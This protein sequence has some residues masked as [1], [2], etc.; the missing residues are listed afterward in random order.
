MTGYLAADELPLQRIYRWERERPEAVFLTQPYGGKVRD[1]TWGQAVSEVRRMAHWLEAQGWEPGSRVA[2]LSRNCAWW[3]LA[4][5]AIWMAGHVT[6]PIYPSLKAA[7][8]AQDSGAQRRQGL[9]SGRYRRTRKPPETAHSA[10]SDLRGSPFPLPATVANWPT[11]DEL[12]EANPPVPG[13]PDAVRRRSVHH[14][15]HLRHHRQAQGGD[16]QLRPPAR[17]DAKILAGLMRASPARSAYCRICHWPTSWSAA[18]EG[19][20][21][22][23]GYHLFF[24]EGIDTFLADLARARPTCSFRCRGCCSN[25]SRECSPRS[26]RDSWSGCCASP[27]F[28]VLVKQRILRQ[29]GLEHRAQRRLRG[30]A[31]AAG[32]APLV[33]Q[34]GAGPAGRLRH[35]RNHD[36]PP[37]APRR[38]VRP[39]YVGAALE[40]VETRLGPQD[41][42][43]VRSP[44]N[45]AGLFPGAG[46]DGARRSPQ[47][48]FFKTGDLVTH[49]CLTGKSRSSDA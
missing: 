3:I 19:T 5:L 29:L 48:G 22:Y 32:D 40:G 36:H 12:V 43:L 18:M 11:W 4:D 26:R 46:D 21:L 27:S 17:F 39:G 1:W 25:S 33:P 47:D 14:H 42:L 8:H 24:T 23:L 15:L 28:T 37:A 9:L 10:G 49:R 35:D 16:A 38:S 41:E 2:I 44:M 13:Y 30:R 7:V 20:A 6:V 31:A 45:M 34:P